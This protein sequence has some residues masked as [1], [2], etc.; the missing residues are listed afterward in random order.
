MA[1]QNVSVPPKRANSTRKVL[2]AKAGARAPASRQGKRRPW[3]KVGETPAFRNNRRSHGKAAFRTPATPLS[4]V[5][6]VVENPSGRAALMF[7]EAAK[8]FSAN[9]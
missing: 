8:R 9:G 1:K 6:V 5:R 4:T 7:A 2:V 3:Q